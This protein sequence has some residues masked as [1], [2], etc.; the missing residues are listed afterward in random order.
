MT[1]QIPSNCTVEYVCD[2]SI[3]SQR[4]QPDDA[5]RGRIELL[6]SH[7]CRVTDQISLD[8]NFYKA[9]LGVQVVPK[10][11][12]LIITVRLDT[13]PRDSLDQIRYPRYFANVYLEL[14]TVVCLSTASLIV[15]ARKEARNA[16]RT[17]YIQID[18]GLER[19][20]ENEKP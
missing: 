20:W 16:M 5:D 7:F 4:S 10:N 1:T 19:N 9:D 18:D 8:G 13:T 11:E 12:Q 17:I 6:L 14:E 2:G 15:L 3:E